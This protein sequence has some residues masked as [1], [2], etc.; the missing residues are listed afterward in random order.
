MKS[1][2]G[3]ALVT[4]AAGGIG[5]AAAMAFGRAGAR[6]LVTDRRAAELADTMRQLQ[7]SGFD[8]EARTCDQTREGEVAEL[9]A[10]AASVGGLHSTFVNAGYGRYGALI[11]IPADQWRRH[12]DV[13]LT[14]GFLVAQGAAR[15]M[16]T[17][18]GGAIVFNASTAA[19]FPCDLLGAYASAKAGIAMLSRSMASEF[20][21]YGIRVNTV[22]P[23]VIETSMTQS[24]LDDPAT[25]AD[26]LAETPVGRLGRPEDIADAVVFL[27][28]DASGYITGAELLVDGGQTIHAYPRWFKP[29]RP[30]QT[31]EWVPQSMPLR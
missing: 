15:L 10:F 9:C 21:A 6:L 31:P 13:N 23:G 30:G 26:V 19:T 18:G 14:G 3:R 20:G 28:S 12:V 1:R 22:M 27:C 5:L 17:S 16:R 4:G 7:A 11:D 8:V 24:L 29:N 2:Q 25:R